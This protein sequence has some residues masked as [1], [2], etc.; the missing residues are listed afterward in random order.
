MRLNLW[1]LKGAP[2]SLKPAKREKFEK[3]RIK[4]KTKNQAIF[5]LILCKFPY[6]RNKFFG[7]KLWEIFRIEI[8]P[9][10]V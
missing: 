8:G 10:A 2:I 5:Q 7:E 3:K 1:D 9:T 4:S 6:S